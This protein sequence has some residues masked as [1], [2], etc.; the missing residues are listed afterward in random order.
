MI[1]VFAGPQNLLKL[2]K[3]HATYRSSGFVRSQVAADNIRIRGRPHWTEIISA[4]QIKCRIK[5]C[6]FLTKVWVMSL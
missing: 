5:F 1:E 2:P 4:A 3:R 6:R